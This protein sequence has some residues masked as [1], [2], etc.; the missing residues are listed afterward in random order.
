[1]MNRLVTADTSGPVPVARVAGEVDLAN[2]SRLRE[3]LLAIAGDVD[4]LVVDLT[5]VPYLDSA[6]VKA[7]FQVARDLRQRDQSLIVTMPIGSPLR[8][9]LKIT[10]FHEVA[11]ICDDI[12]AA[13]D[14][15]RG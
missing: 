14:L 7:L 11:T 13:F 2:A 8:R 3:E 1:M 5:E 6:G 15:L 10:S 9:V 12:D 4:S